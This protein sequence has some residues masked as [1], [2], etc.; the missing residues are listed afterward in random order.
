MTMSPQE[1][2]QRFP[3]QVAESAGWRV[4]YRCAGGAQKV[5]HVLLHGIGSASASWVYQ[6]LAA[7]GRA[8]VRVLAWDA[9]GYGASTPFEQ[10]APDASDY[11]LRLWGWLNALGVNGPVV[12]T[13]HSLGA[14]MAASAARLQ[15]ERVERVL[16]LSP[17][18]GYGDAAAVE[19]EDK[20][21]SRLG[22]LERLGPR[23]MAEARGA[24]MLSPTA[25]PNLIEAVKEAMANV[26]PVG[27]AQAARM[28]AQGTLLEDLAHL[29][30]PVHV[31][32]GEAD[33]I[34]PP[35]SCSLVAR[36]AGQERLSLGPV[37]HACP[38]EAARAVN[39]LLGLT[40]SDHEHAPL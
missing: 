32:S 35:A 31:A 20:L 34:T 15:P 8:D 19:R 9:P 28:L 5:T 38:L 14:L 40:L 7:E 3:V 23:G 26:H 18:R 21:N 29:R 37:G 17:A 16:L 24:A 6:L 27:Y 30:C 4:Q 10:S 12:L 11:A 33:T 39:A 36:E 13:G 2:L 1:A 25:A 22:M